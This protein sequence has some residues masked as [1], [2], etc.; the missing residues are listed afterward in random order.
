MKS[1][2]I[3]FAIAGC[4]LLVNTTAFSQSVQTTNPTPAGKPVNSHIQPIVSKSTKV[5]AATPVG[6]QQVS[7]NS[8]SHSLKPIA[9][10]KSTANTPALGTAS[11]QQVNHSKHIAPRSVSARSSSVKAQPI[12]NT[13]K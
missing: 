3:V 9:V 7:V 6:T 2:L 11:N 4:L 5:Q 12:T 8:H 1:K 10:N 13:N